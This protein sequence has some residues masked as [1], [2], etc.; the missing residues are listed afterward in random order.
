MNKPYH[1]CLATL[2]NELRIS[3]IKELLKNP[4]S[5]GEL[6]KKLNEEQSKISHSLKILKACKFVISSNKGKERIYSLSSNIFK[7]LKGN[8]NLF[9]IL[10]DHYNNVCKGHCNKKNN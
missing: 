1:K 3:I 2:S 5:V 4:K 10:D 8:K 6:A 9:E 7:K